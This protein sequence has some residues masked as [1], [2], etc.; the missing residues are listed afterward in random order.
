M[1]TTIGYLF[2]IRLIN[3]VLA[4]LHM[5]YLVKIDNV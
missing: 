2:A 4:F 3:G 1:S 5:T